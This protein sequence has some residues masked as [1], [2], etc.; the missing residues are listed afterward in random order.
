MDILR[1]NGARAIWIDQDKKVNQYLCF[2]SEF[3]VL[4]VDKTTFY[5][6]ADT[7]YEFYINGEFAGFGQYEDYPLKKVYDEYDITSFLKQ[8]KNLLSVLAYSQGEDSFQHLA[9][10]PMVIF[11]ATTKTGCLIASDH[12]IK[13]REAKEFISGDFERITPQRSFNFGFDLRLDDGWRTEFVS[14]NW[15][16]AMICDD[17][18][19]TYMPRPN[20]NLELLEVCSGTILTQGYFSINEGKSVAEQMQYA[21]LAYAEKQTVFSSSEDKLEPIGENIYWISDLGEEMA[22]YIVIDVEAEE[23]AILDIACGEHLEDMRVRSFVGGRNF[24]FRCVCREGRRKIC[25]YIRRLAGRYLEVFAHKG[26]RVIHQLGLHKV[27]YPLEFM[28]EFCSTDRLF[29]QIYRTS[30]RTLHLC[31]HEH[32]EDCPQR[33]QALYGMDSRN[34]MLTGYYAFGETLM[35]RSSL[36]LLAMGQREDGLFEICAPAKYRQTIPSF[37]LAWVLALKEYALFSGDLTF[38]SKMQQVAK[39]V[40]QFFVSRMEQNVILREHHPGIWNFYEWTDGM[41]N[42]DSDTSIK[43]DAPLNALFVMASDAYAD[44]CEWI[45]AQEEQ[46]WAKHMSEIVRDAFHTTFYN[47]KTGAYQSYIGDGVKPCFSQLTQSF[48]LLANCVP[49]NLKKDIRAKSVSGELVATSLSY[50]IFQYDALLQEPETYG[51]FV[52][53]DIERQWGYMLYHGATSFWE[54]ILGE[55][56]FDRAGSLCHGWSAVPIYIFWRYIA[57]VYPTSPGKWEIGQS[58]CGENVGMKGT[59]QTAEGIKRL[60]KEGTKINFINVQ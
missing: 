52:L 4:T 29:N 16:N 6:A 51:D 32:Y 31:M 56:D 40:L 23:G 60:T 15:A 57:G 13:C 55:A 37:A 34:Q 42:L 20:R 28:S 35:P 12:Q 59:L 44:L 30:V 38:V 21:S 5:I 8:G 10:L 7:K 53:N 2:Q 11:A 49:E 3:D 45:A 26:I 41:D 9:G 39:N 43:A 46:I 48:A 54:T 47:E 14:E 22:G 27:E 18:Q 25:F 58:C 50:L 24:A 36:E 19:I 17:S 1:K 33:E